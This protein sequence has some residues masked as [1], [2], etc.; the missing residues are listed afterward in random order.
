MVKEKNN[1]K[2]KLLITLI[3]VV[4]LSIAAAGQAAAIW[5]ALTAEKFSL[6]LKIVIL[7]IPLGLIAALI[8]VYT[9]RVKELKNGIE[10][11]L[12]KY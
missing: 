9:E 7:L 3:W 12:D 6:F 8:V 4:L 11:D 2:K 1:T 10:N 5:W